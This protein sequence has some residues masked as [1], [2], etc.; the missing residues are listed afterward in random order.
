MVDEFL[1]VRGLQLACVVRLESF[2]LFKDLCPVIGAGT[3]DIRIHNLP[4]VIPKQIV[5]F[6]EIATDK[7]A[8]FW[9]SLVH[10][11]PYQIS[12]YAV[13]IKNG[14][15]LYSSFLRTTVTLRPSFTFPV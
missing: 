9:V 8:E 15:P 2:D 13:R 10:F 12:T 6:M 3:L 5:V 7:L 14:I 1:P 4:E 11:L